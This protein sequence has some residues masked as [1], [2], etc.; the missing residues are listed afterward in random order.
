V[1]QDQRG[2]T[3]V[4]VIAVTAITA[5]IAVATSMSIF[6]VVKDTERNNEHIT[7]VNQVRSASQWISH[8]VRRGQQL[9]LDGLVPPD[10]LIV[11]WTDWDSG[12]KHEITYTL[13][14]MPGTESK[15]LCR[16]ETINGDE[17]VTT[18]V[19]QYI[20]SNPAKTSCE[21]NSGKLILTITATVSLGLQ[22]KSE[23]RVFEILPRPG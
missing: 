6:Q 17:P 20:D 21:L 11:K 1:N 19:A 7:A 2:F 16:S 23:T 15:Q 13:E 22:T 8:D 5:I 18:F 12:D 9:I 4:E 3:L 14:D 10:F